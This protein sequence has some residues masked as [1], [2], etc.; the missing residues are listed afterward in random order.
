RRRAPGHRALQVPAIRA[1][2]VLQ[3]GDVAVGRAA[4]RTLLGDAD[5]VVEV[6]AG[7]LNA[8][9]LA[10]VGAEARFEEQLVRP[11]RAPRRLLDALAEA[12]EVGADFRRRVR[13][14]RRVA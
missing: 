10:P 14:A 6:A 1:G 2:A 7:M 11:R 3:V 4:R 8:A 9:P 12:R 5:E 13:R